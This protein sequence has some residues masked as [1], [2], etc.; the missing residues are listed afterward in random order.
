MTETI[1]CYGELLL[2]LGAPGR[3]RLLQSPLL[4]VHVGGAE[5]NVGVSLAQLG[6]PVRMIGRVADNPLGQAALGELRRHGVQTGAMQLAEGRM[7]LYFLTTGALQR[8]SEVVYDRAD[9]VFARGTAA[10]YD[11]PALL[12]G[13]RWLHL[14]GV[15]PALGA[16]VAETAVAAAQA[17]RAAGLGV[18]FDGNFRPKLWE[19]WGGDA[20]GILH[21]LMDQA[22]VLF[23]D[24]RDIAVVLG[25]AFDQPEAA[26]RNRAA[27]AAAFAAFPN[28]RHMACTLRQTYSVDHHGL[29]AM[30]LTRE[31]A[32]L[33]APTREL[34]GVV[35]RIGGGDAFAAGI[36]HGLLSALPDAQT[37]AFG[38]AAGCLKHSI[39]G[40]FNLASEAEIRALMGEGRLD[41]RR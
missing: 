34:P 9:S 14:S 7:G 35:D 32:C 40:D 25:Q 17:A 30:L 6:H 22:D 38:L 24:H 18:S 36:L 1:A 29:G 41:V 10:D 28:L 33:E 21:R 31:G 13:C 2:R 26:A 3:Q 20:P 37:L 23:A 12:D 15:T 19:A 5:A 8:P 4:E 39:E 27:A 11:W 16:E